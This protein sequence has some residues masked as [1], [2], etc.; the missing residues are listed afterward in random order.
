M[1]SCS[2]YDSVERSVERPGAPTNHLSQFRSTVV[3]RNG[4]NH[5]DICRDEALLSTFKL[6]KRDAIDIR[7]KPEVKFINEDGLD[8]SGPRR[9][10]FHSIMTRLCEGEGSINLFE[11]RP[12][13][14]LPIHDV[15]LLASGF[16]FYCGKL[17]AWS[18]VHEGI[19]IFDISNAAQEY[20]I[21]Q[22]LEKA[23]PLVSIDDVCDEG[24]ITVLDNVRI[25]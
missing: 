15:D 25:Y 6:L 10:Y 21:S 17:I 18:A 2:G 16:Y 20:I 14:K 8:A 5:V 7:K 12:G 19:G 23:I 13:H 1:Q 3:L 4:F 11:G 22:S 9:E 24:I